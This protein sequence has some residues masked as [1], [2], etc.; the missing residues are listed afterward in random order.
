MKNDIWGVAFKLALA[1][2]VC[3]LVMLI[4]VGFDKTET[5]ICIMTAVINFVFAAVVFVVIRVRAS[6]DKSSNL[7]SDKGE[8]KSEK[9]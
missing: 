4:I 3:S 7:K 8:G 2:L 9:Q 5:Y 6:K 1:L